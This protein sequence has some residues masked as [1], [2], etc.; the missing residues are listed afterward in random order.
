MLIRLLRRLGWIVLGGLAPALVLAGWNT[1][2]FGGPLSFSYGFK[3]HP[4]L[5]ATHA[6]LH[7]YASTPVHH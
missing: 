4:A 7:P 3:A 6:Y 5:A 2:A 1:L